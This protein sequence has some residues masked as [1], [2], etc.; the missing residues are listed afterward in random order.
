MTAIQANRRARVMSRTAPAATP[1]LIQPLRTLE[2]SPREKP[3]PADPAGD[4]LR[5][6]GVAVGQRRVERRA[7]VAEVGGDR[8]QPAA[9]PFAAQRGSAAN[10]EVGVVAHVRGEHARRLAGRIQAL[11]AVV[12]ERLQHVAAGV[13]LD[14]V[15]L[16]HDQRLVGEAR[17]E[18]GH[19]VV[20]DVIVGTDRPS[21][22]QGARSAEDREPVE[23][24]AFVVEQ[25][26]VAPVDDGA[27]RLLA[28][29]RGAGATVE[30]AEAI[31]ETRRELA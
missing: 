8:P 15:A 14:L 31:F 6:F 17:D 28:G 26:L 20:G 4:A 25:Q 10:R 23:D 22:G 27:E 18:L 21:G 30:H 12:D 24:A 11:A 29:E 13:A 1:G 16:H 5:G 2:R 19:V 3:I 7:E 9:L